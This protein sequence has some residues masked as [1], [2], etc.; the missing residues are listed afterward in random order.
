[1]AFNVRVLP[2][3]DH[4]DIRGWVETWDKLEAL[5][6]SVII[7]GHGG[8]TDIKTVTKFTKDYLVYMLTEVEKVIDNDGELID[9]YK[10]DVS[11]FIQWDTFNE[12]SK[13]NAERIFRKLEFE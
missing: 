3:L 10:I 1:L 11:R 2:I 13:R 7:P 12:L 5:N 4:T 6:A 8:P 9:A